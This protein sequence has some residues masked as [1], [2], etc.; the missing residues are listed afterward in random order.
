LT[1]RH[2]QGITGYAQPGDLMALMG[3]QGE[4]DRRR[5]AESSS[6]ADCLGCTLQPCFATGRQ[7]P[8]LMDLLHLHPRPHRC[9]GGSGAG[10]TT[11]MDVLCGRKTVGEVRGDIWVN[12][13]PKEQASWS[14]VVGYC[15]QND[16]HTA[17]QVRWVVPPTPRR[18]NS[19]YY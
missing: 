11:L 10:K 19:E 18:C 3:K 7:A 6:T 17:A 5:A 12:G 2:L 4:Q 8:R 14:R 13:H 15:E 16:I 9:A 1:C